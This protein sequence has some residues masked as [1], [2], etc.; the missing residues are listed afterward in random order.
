M[1]VELSEAQKQLLERAA[2]QQGTTV[3]ELMETATREFLTQRLGKPATSSKP[4]F[5]RPRPICH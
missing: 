3:E 2:K 4:R 1:E 5:N